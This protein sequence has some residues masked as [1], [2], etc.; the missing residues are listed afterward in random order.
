MTRADSNFE[1]TDTENGCS[2]FGGEDFI[3]RSSPSL[4]KMMGGFGDMRYNFTSSEIDDV[5]LD[6][7]E[8]VDLNIKNCSEN[9]TVAQSGTT[10]D[11]AFLDAQIKLWEK[12]S[13]KSSY[14]EEDFELLQGLQNPDPVYFPN[15]DYTSQQ[16]NVSA[17]VRA[18]LIDWM[19]EVC[20]DFHLKRDTLYIAVNYLDRY[21]SIV[22]NVELKDLQCVAISCV[23]LAS[24]MEEVQPQKVS[25]FA[26][27]TDGCC[28]AEQ[29]I[30]ME[31]I[32]CKVTLR[33][34]YQ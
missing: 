11:S 7:E 14:A 4:E 17:Q 20:K 3:F 12:N 34:W 21:F 1:I 26:K 24:K 33:L 9:T 10:Q 25:D 2:E 31:L 32:I 8:L 15:P 22:S 18:T 19:I 27:L 30:Q 29:I 28:T 23:Y 5:N 16:P 6:C 13:R